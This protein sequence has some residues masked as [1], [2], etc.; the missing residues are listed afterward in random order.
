MKP[1][2]ITSLRLPRLTP[3]DRARYDAFNERLVVVKRVCIAGPPGLAGTIEESLED[4][5]RFPQYAT[6]KEESNA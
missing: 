1:R 6:K 5:L 3:E 4:P 2:Q